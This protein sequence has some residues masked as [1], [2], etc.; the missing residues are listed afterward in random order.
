MRISQLVVKVF[1]PKDLDFPSTL[2]L[3]ILS[4]QMMVYFFQEKWSLYIAIIYLNVILM[5]F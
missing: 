5:Y 4:G 2:A 1:N 3:I